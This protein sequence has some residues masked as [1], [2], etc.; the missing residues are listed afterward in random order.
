MDITVG[1]LVIQTPLLIPF[2]GMAIFLGLYAITSLACWIVLFAANPVYRAPSESPGQSSDAT[3]GGNS[4]GANATMAMFLATIPGL[5]ALSS[6]FTLVTDSLENL[7]LAITS[8]TSTDLI[9]FLIAAAIASLAGALI[10][11]GNVLIEG[12]WTAYQCNILPTV[13]V[14][15]QLV[16]LGN[17]GLGTAWPGITFYASVSWASI[18]VTYRVLIT[19][20]LANADTVLTDLLVGIAN[21]LLEFFSAINTFIQSGV[22]NEQHGRI[23]FIPF[24]EAIGSLAGVATSIADC[25]CSYLSF[26][27]YPPPLSS[28]LRLIY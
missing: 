7:F 21:A 6:G 27:T 11:Y 25:S 10:V 12:F 9:S 22:E 26:A 2:F 1:S 13:N 28:V 18:G 5:G 14:L 20:G 15:L 4:A 16:N 24:M 3:G 19:C 23:G 17:L 8:F